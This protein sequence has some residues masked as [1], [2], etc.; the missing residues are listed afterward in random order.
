M[1]LLIASWSIRFA[2]VA[3]AAVGGISFF[4]GSSPIE[5]FDR[6]VGAAFVF[7][8]VGRFLLGRLETPEQRMQLLRARRAAGKGGKSKGEKG[9][10]AE[11]GDKKAKGKKPKKGE[12]ID[13]GVDGAPQAAGA[14]AARRRAA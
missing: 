9:E 8:L 10:K 7:I 5:S 13:D 4:V 2:M 1:E 12:E 14:A 6:A 11:K 3:A